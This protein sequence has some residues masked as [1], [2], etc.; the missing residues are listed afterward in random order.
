VVAVT[1][2]SAAHPQGDRGRPVILL[3]HGR[4]MLDRDTAATRRL[5]FGGIMSGARALTKLPLLDERDVRIVWYADV[6]D[7][8]STETCD[9]A[10]TDPRAR[11]DAKTDNDFKQFT[12][13]AGGF[14]SLI[15]AIASDTES[16]SQVRSL[17]AD[18][19]FLG[20]ARKRCASESRLAAAIDR[21]RSEGRPI[22]LVAHSLGSLMA[23]DHLSARTDT[24]IVQRFV[25]FGSV[26]GAPELR[27][28]LIG[29]DSTDAFTVPSAVKEWVNVR[30]DLDMFAV[31]LSIGR[32][33]VATPPADERDPHEMVGY[34][35]STVGAREILGAWC[36]AFLDNR[37]QGCKDV[38][39]R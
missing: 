29:G 10:S 35:R 14:L 37:L 24:G 20:D 12:S 5:W 33:V 22:V 2:A 6:L 38:I 18:A 17:A 9:Y 34:L 4:G 15:A 8:R 25:T 7:P 21:A 32:D 16:A 26:V 19:S 23:Y 31:P 11:R 3:V 30:N 28:L 36:A 13:L 27:H 1:F 39:S